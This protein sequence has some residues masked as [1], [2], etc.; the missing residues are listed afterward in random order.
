MATELDNKNFDN[1]II[2]NDSYFFKCLILCL[3]LF[4]QTFLNFLLG[5]DDLVRNMITVTKSSK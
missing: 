3:F 2:F 5:S 1:I 4:L